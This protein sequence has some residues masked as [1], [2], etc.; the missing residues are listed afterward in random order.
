MKF[1][2]YEKIQDFRQLEY[3][4]EH[5]MCDTEDDKEKINEVARELEKAGR[6]TWDR[7]AQKSGWSTTTVRKYYDKD[8]YPGKFF[9]KNRRGDLRSPE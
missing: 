3:D 5:C 1:I 7:L 8:W 4:F 9:Q 6:F 2:K